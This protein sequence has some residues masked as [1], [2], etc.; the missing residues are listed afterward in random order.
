MVANKRLH[1]DGFST[2]DYTVNELEAGDVL[3]NE[4]QVD[5]KIIADNNKEI[6]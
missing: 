4:V 6:L 3:F 2:G 5:P 1:C